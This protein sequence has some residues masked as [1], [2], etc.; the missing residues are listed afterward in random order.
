M[1]KARLYDIVSAL[2]EGGYK[3][4][5]KAFTAKGGDHNHV[6]LLVIKVSED[7]SSDDLVAAHRLHNNILGWYEEDR[8]W[9]TVGKFERRAKSRAA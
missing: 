1:P 3:L 6:M 9:E 2:Q 5:V 8:L 7:G 4:S